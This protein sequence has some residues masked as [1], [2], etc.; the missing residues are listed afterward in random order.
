MAVGNNTNNGIP[1]GV[2]Y[3]SRGRAKSLMEIGSL[4]VN[5]VSATTYLNMPSVGGAS[6][7]SGLND[8]CDTT[9][10]DGQS[11][12]WNA[13][14]GNWCPAT[15]E[16]TSSAVAAGV[17]SF[18][19]L[20]EVITQP[21][22]LVNTIPYF[23][24]TDEIGIDTIVNVVTVAGNFNISPG[25][26]YATTATVNS[27]TVSIANLTVSSEDLSAAIATNITN[28]SNNDTDIANLTT[29]SA[30]LSAAIDANTTYISDNEAAWLDGG[31][32]GGAPSDALYITTQANAGLSNE[33][34][35]SNTPSVIWVT[36]GGTASALAQ[37][38]AIDHSLLLNIAVG[39][40][41]NQYTLTATNQVLSSLVSNIETSTIDTSAYINANET[42]WSVD[43]DNN[44]S[45]LADLDDTANIVA[46][47]TGQVLMK[48]ATGLW[49]PSTSPTG[50]TDHSLLSNLAADDHPQYTLTATN[51][52]LSAAVTDNDTD[53]A[54]L[55]T[56]SSD[57]SSA[58]STNISDI[59]A[60]DT[61]IANLTTSSAD[62]SAAID[63]NTS[64]ITSNDG[65]ITYVSGEY[66]NHVASAIAHSIVLEKS[67]T[68]E[69]PVVGDNITLMNAVQNYSITAIQT[70][71]SATETPSATWSLFAGTDRSAADSTLTTV[72]TSSTTGQSITPS[73]ISITS[74]QYV[75]ITVDA[76]VGTF[77]DLHVSL[78][79]EIAT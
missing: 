12:V 4:S 66:D 53:I 68:I 20:S 61:D 67:I 72:T 77:T 57:L 32:G 62:L 76:V 28:I 55:T 47:T 33:Q 26:S 19:S 21:P 48:L 34:V 35:L 2:G 11:L 40:P 5:T 73:P 10:T 27:N 64:N 14:N 49:E 38:S 51:A 56:S 71:C 3:D 9:A 52:N 17:S 24:A 58:I 8:V 79:L 37:A 1:V 54:N 75:W 16:I 13:D 23:S 46:A 6:S 39:D 78:H 41:H 65:D 29:S 43:T 69:S 74:S 30:D 15:I 31:G 70:V 45:S 22:Y 25:V 44:T 36:G 7:L 42:S 60:N 63:A 59:G 50:V 18:S